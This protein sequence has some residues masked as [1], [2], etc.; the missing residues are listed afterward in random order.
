MEGGE[1]VETMSVTITNLPKDMNDDFWKDAIREAQKECGV[2][3][4]R[5]SKM[6]VNG[7]FLMENY[8][9]EFSTLMASIASCYVASV[10]SAFFKRESE[11]DI[12]QWLKIPENMPSS[13]G[14]YDV[15]FERK[16]D[17]EIDK[18]NLWWNGKFFCYNMG[19]KRKWKN[20]SWTM[21]HFNPNP[22]QASGFENMPI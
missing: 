4:K 1:P 17:K 6:I 10:A 3:I 20:N 18:G 21:T 7:K 9:E 5:S 14:V 22:K 16:K 19:K 15:R 11:E 2:P 8:P 13:K 12:S